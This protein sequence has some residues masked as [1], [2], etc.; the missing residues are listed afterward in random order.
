MMTT[1]RIHKRNLAIFI[2][3]SLHPN[4]SHPTNK[5]VAVIVVLPLVISKKGPLNTKKCHPFILHIYILI[6]RWLYIGPHAKML[7]PTLCTNQL[8]LNFWQSYTWSSWSRLSLTKVCSIQTSKDV[9][10]KLVRKLKEVEIIEARLHEMND[11]ITGGH[12]HKGLQSL[13]IHSCYKCLLRIER[14]NCHSWCTKPSWDDK[15][16]NECCW[17]VIIQFDLGK[18]RLLMGKLETQT[19][20]MHASS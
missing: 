13:K 4:H 5:L 6:K 14:L 11:T 16:K 7:L 20:A 1:G 19:K 12:R 3:A 10:F 18:S 2:H 8:C 9:R 17:E 15:A